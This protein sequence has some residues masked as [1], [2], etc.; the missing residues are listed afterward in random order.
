MFQ[1]CSNTNDQGNVGLG[2]AIAYFTTVGWAVS[3]PLNDTQAYDLIVDSGTQ[4]HRVQ[5][6]TTNLKNKYGNYRLRLSTRGGNWHGPSKKERLFTGECC[7]LI[8]VL[9]GEGQEYLIPAEDVAHVTTATNL[10]KKYDRFA[11]CSSPVSPVLSR[12]SER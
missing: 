2:R 11:I 3:L 12:E 4:L 6:K 1:H 10:G 8:Y 9:T 5:V 7:D